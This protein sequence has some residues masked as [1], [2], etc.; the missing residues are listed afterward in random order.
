VSEDPQYK[1]YEVSPETFA[2]LHRKHVPPAYM[3]SA[4][5]KYNGGYQSPK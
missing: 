1:P 3:T 4:D 5:V 2:H